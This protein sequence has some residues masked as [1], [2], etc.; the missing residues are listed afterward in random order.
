M[1]HARYRPASRHPRCGDRAGHH[2][3]GIVRWS[4]HD[5]SRGHRL[6]GM[7]EA[8]DV[9]RERFSDRGV[10][11]SYGAARETPLLDFLPPQIL[12]APFIAAHV[13]TVPNPVS[14]R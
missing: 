8:H 7:T 4:V 5:G 12:E 14:A 9:A 1:A 2:P 6:E 10:P 3:S 13:L 11:N